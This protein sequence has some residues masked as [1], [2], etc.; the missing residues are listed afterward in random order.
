MYETMRFNLNESFVTSLLVTCIFLRQDHTEGF[1]SFGIVLKLLVL[2]SIL[3]ENSDIF[4][5]SRC[6]CVEQNSPNVIYLNIRNSSAIF[7]EK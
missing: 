3:I 1:F 5:K 6:V 4:I 7:A 2:K